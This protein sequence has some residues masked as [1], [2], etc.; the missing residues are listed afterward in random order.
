M[1]AAKPAEP[2]RAAPS[3]PKAVAIRRQAGSVIRVAM[4]PSPVPSSSTLRISAFLSISPSSPKAA[5]ATFSS[6]R[7]AT[8]SAAVFTAAMFASK[9]AISRFS[10]APNS[11]AACCFAWVRSRKRQPAMPGSGMTGW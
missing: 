3:K 6:R 8:R 11:K 2:V 9:C 7:S 10:S 1:P 5:S 4:A